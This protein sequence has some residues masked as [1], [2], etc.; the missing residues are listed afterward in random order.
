MKQLLRL[1]LLGLFVS[2]MA[3]AQ[4]VPLTWSGELRLR[5]ELDAR[6]MR[7]STPPNLYT[8][9]RARIGMLARPSEDVSVFLQV[10]DARAFGE[11]ATPMSSLNSA[12]VHQAW[13]EVKDLLPGLRV[14]AGKMELSVGNGRL[15]SNNVW[16][17]VPRTLT[18]LVTSLDLGKH[19]VTALLFNTRETS[20]LPSAATKFAWTRDNGDLLTGGTFRTTALERHNLEIIALYH[21]IGKADALG[22]DS[23]SVAS[24]GGFFAGKT[25]A[26]SYEADAAYQTGSM[27]GTDVAS[28]Q[29]GALI[30][31]VVGHQTVRSV[32]A[33]LDLYSG[34]TISATA[35]GV[36]DPRYG[37]GHKNLGFMDYFTSIPAHTN[38]RGIIDAYGR[39]DL[40]W[41]DAVETQLTVHHFQLHRTLSVAV[42]STEIGQE[43][44]VITRWKH[45]SALSVEFGAGIFLPGRAMQSII[46]GSD[47]GVWFYLSPQISF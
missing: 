25:G 30:T 45:S 28:Y 20:A 3:F 32:T 4:S 39:A 12:E 40:S 13:L 6:D 7:N 15:I 37:A 33:A 19:T 10:Q 17:N 14:K 11:A 31:Y 27:F 22:R 29:A 36:F 16:V 8:L 44:D 1:L 34:E 21:R 2:P 35:V 38:R 24:L 46:G 18:G 47:P 42:P 5:S 9:S 43:V 23:L 26:W 41:S